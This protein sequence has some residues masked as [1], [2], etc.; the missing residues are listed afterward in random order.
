M[1]FDDE[2]HV[3]V[4]PREV[5]QLALT[6]KAR[7]INSVLIP[8]TPQAFPAFEGY[9]ELLHHIT[10]N[11]GIHPN[12][13]FFKGS[14]KI[15]FSIAPKAKKAWMEYGP[16]SDLDLAIVDP[17]FF[18]VVD[19]E[20]GRWERNAANRDDMFQGGRRFREYKD[21]NK[22]KGTH[23]CF[24]FFDLPSIACMDTLTECLATAPVKECCGSNRPLTAFVF[25]DWWGVFKRYDSDLHQ[26]CRG[27]KSTTDPIPAGED[28][29]RPYVELM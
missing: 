5:H 21:R 24:R 3:I 20:V 2:G 14:T 25:R 13:L 11:M 18:Q 12:N 8:G 10:E 19:H 6:D 28:T 9:R 15:G 27:L 4:T 29:P 16:G 1:K 17:G 23:D 7:L 22:H 26:L